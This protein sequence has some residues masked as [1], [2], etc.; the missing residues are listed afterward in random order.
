MSKTKEKP[1]NNVN[2]KDEFDDYIPVQD[3]VFTSQ[4]KTIRRFTH[5]CNKN[6]KKRQKIE[7]K[8]NEV[9]DELF[10]FDKGLDEIFKHIEE[11]K[12]ITL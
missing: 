6:E 2:S 3:Y 12:K 11:I 8:L 7:N 10:V 9:Y 1:N 4:I 5:F